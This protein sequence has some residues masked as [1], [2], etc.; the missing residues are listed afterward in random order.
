MEYSIY[1]TDNSQEILDKLKELG[2]HICICCRFKDVK[3]LHFYYRTLNVKEPIK[4]FHGV[5]NRC[6]N[7]CS[8]ANSDKCIMCSIK[9]SITYNKHIGIFSNMEN[10]INFIN[11]KYK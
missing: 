4:E 2:F 8:D 9:D 5:G 11:S 1:Y 6:E 10:L 3:W 7:D